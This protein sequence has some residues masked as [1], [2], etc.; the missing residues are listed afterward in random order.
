MKRLLP[1][2]PGVRERTPWETPIVS[3]LVTTMSIE[4][5]RS[6]SQV[7][8]NIRLEVAD[9]PIASTIRGANNAVYF[10]REKFYC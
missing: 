1:I 8:G 3:S 6:S 7:P 5:L 10:T 9:G 2:R 4:E